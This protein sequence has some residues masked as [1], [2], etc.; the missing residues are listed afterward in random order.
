MQVWHLFSSS[1]QDFRSNGKNGQT[2]QLLA[3]QH[4]QLRKQVQALQ[5]SLLPPSSSMPVKQGPC[6]LILKKKDPG[7][8]NQVPEETSPHLQLGAQYN[9]WVW[10]NFLWSPQEPLLAT[11]MRRKLAWFGHVT[12]HDSL[13]KTILQG[14]LEGG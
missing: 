9:D 8:R 10:I 14:T 5:V 2:R 6:S 3:A 4:H 12:H 11:V 13:S 1:H 7:F